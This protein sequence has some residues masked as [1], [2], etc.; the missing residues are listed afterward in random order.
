M[1]VGRTVQRVRIDERWV[2]VRL[3]IARPMPIPCVG[4]VNTAEAVADL[5]AE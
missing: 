5:Y 2:L 1:V 4:R 3:P